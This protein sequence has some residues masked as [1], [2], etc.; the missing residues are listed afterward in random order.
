MSEPR[1]QDLNTK[2]VGQASENRLLMEM[3]VELVA[4]LY[5]GGDRRVG[6][7]EEL[8]LRKDIQNC[9]AAK[10]N[11]EALARVQI[12]LAELIT[13]EMLRQLLTPE[14]ITEVLGDTISIN[15]ASSSAQK[16]A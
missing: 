4:F 1:P 11:S 16:A 7:G 3:P 9:Q 10:D 6:V 13:P 15:F 2:C 14:M 8:T 12:V 5:H